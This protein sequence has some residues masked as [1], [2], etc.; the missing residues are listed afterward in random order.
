MIA[1]YLYMSI[2][3][4]ITIITLRKISVICSRKIVKFYLVIYLIKINRIEL[5]YQ[6]VILHHDLLSF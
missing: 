2:L 6:F 4:R 5:F 3:L 1:F